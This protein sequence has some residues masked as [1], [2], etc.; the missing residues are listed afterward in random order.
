MYKEAAGTVISVKKTVVAK[1]K[2]QAR[3]ITRHGRRNVSPHC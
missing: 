3:E 2:R 1:G